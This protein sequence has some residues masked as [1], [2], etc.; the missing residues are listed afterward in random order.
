ML[1]TLMALRCALSEFCL[2]AWIM[3]NF[4]CDQNGLFGLIK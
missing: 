2:N 1:F 3:E 4:I